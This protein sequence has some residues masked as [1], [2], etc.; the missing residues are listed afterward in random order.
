M[1]RYPL[2][3]MSKIYQSASTKEV[4]CVEESED[5]SKI[6]REQFVKVL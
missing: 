1:P 3:R 6:P 4:K 2:V 5:G